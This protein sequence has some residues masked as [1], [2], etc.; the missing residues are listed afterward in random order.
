M[1]KADSFSSKWAFIFSALGMAIGAGNIW[2]FPRIAAQNGGGTFLIA[3]MIALFIWSIPIIILEF[4]MGKRA[5]AGVI[6]AFGII[7]G[8]RYCWMGGFIAFCTTAIMFYYSVVTGWCIRYMLFALK[9]TILH[10]DPYILWNNF[11]SGKTPVL[12]HF[13]SIS[14]AAFVVS[15]GIAK[16]IEKINDVLI[17]TLFFLIAVAATK[18]LFLP[19]AEKGLR[20]LFYPDIGRLLDY[21]IWLEAITQS[22]WSVGPGWGLILTYA[23]YS[24]KD[25]DIVSTSVIVGLG[26]NLVSILAGIA[27]ICT[28][29]AFLPKQEA[30]KVAEAGNVGLTFLCL[31]TIFKKITHAHTFIFIFFLC[32]SSAA[33]SSLIAMVE[34]AVR[35]LIDMGISRKKAAFL[36]AIVGFFAGLPSAI[37]MDFFCNQDWVWGIGLLLGGFFVTISAIKY[38]VARFRKELINPSESWFK[39]GSYFDM[40]VTYLI[41][42]EFFGLISWWFYK[43]VKFESKSWWN[44]FHKYS[45]AT[46]IFQWGI[47]LIALILLNKKLSEIRELGWSMDKR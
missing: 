43:A 45:I 7:C 26:N 19:N 4:A 47:V 39:L 41:P 3:W 14:L 8:K 2:R 10:S 21:R 32:L 33:F 34:L 17:P 15:L 38:G 40:L 25:Q 37:S 11:I 27:V 6:K 16:G 30:L 35:V 31:P 13:I 1:N 24:R 46:C 44:P 36:I 42:A 20:F 22:A 18:A 5:K 9:S 12:F 29:F 28:L 23:V